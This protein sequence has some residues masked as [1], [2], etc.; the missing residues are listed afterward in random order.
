M[1]STGLDIKA[2]KSA[3][4]RRGALAPWLGF[5]CGAALNTAFKKP[6]YSPLY[7]ATASSPV[8]LKHPVLSATEN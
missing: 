3:G 1:A 8:R 5:D 6:K 7:L 4:S 2:G